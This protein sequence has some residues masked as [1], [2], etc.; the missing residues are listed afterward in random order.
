MAPEALASI[1]TFE[2]EQS[3][4]TRQ[5]ENRIPVENVTPT[6]KPDA[7]KE[8]PKDKESPPQKRM[9]MDIEGTVEDGNQDRTSG[10]NRVKSVVTSD[11]CWFICIFL[12]LFRCV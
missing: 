9:K 7:S 12:A 2:G 8:T 4:V 10:K 1:Q 3:N 6:P 5:Q 11:H